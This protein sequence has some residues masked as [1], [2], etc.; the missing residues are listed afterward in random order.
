MSCDEGHVYNKSHLG[1][2]GRQQALEF[3]DDEQA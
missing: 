1:H 2:I 3:L